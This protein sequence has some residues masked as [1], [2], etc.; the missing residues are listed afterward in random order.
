[1]FR[2]ILVS[3]TVVLVLDVRK[4][5]DGESRFKVVK[6]DPWT[7]WFK[8]VKMTSVHTDFVTPRKS[9]RESDPG[10]KVGPYPSYDRK[11]GSGT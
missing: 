8:V 11:D 3:N 10:V 5:R 7:E 6:M 4:E 1:M 9:G 2:G